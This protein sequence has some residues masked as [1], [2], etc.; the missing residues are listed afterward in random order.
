VFE[1]HRLRWQLGNLVGGLLVR[2]PYWPGWWAQGRE[3]RYLG[4]PGTFALCAYVL[5]LT[6]LI[7]WQLHE[8]WEALG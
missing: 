2:N 7:A 8:I 3:I 4:I 1:H 5:A 6:L